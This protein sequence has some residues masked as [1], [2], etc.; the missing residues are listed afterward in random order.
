MPPEPAAVIRWEEPPEKHGNTRPKPPSKYQPVVDS[1]R[2][3]PGQWAV[4]AENRLPGSAGSLAHYI[5]VGRG[6]FGP[7]GF[8]A[9]VIGPAGGASSR[10]YARYVGDGEAADA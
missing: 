4:I 10:V 5:R 8:E 3:R 2:A 9:K 7:S 1:L 6:P